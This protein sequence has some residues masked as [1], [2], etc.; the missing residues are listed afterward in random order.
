MRLGVLSRSFQSFLDRLYMLQRFKLF[1]GTR[2]FPSSTTV[3]PQH[4]RRQLVSQVHSQKG[5]RLPGALLDGDTACAHLDGSPWSLDVRRSSI[6]HAGLGVFLR[7]SS[8]PPHTLFTL[9][10]GNSYLYMCK[11]P[12]APTAFEIHSCTHLAF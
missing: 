8:A 6:P 2:V 10:P 11:P 1:L 4:L 5:I 9:Y 12:T 3:Q 7:G